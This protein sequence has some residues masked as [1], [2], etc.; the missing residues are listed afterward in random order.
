MQPNVQKHDEIAEWIRF[1]SRF[2]QLANEEQHLVQQ[3]IEARGKI[4]DLY[5][6]A[7]RASESSRWRFGGGATEDFRERV[8]TLAVEASIAIGSPKGADREDFWLHRLYLHL[9]ETKS[10]YLFEQNILQSSEENFPKYGGGIRHVC[11]ASVSFCSQLER[12]ARETSASG[13]VVAPGA[14]DRTAGKQE[15]P[16]TD[17]EQK[18]WS[19]I[20]R[21]LKGPT[22]CRE[23]H[24]AGAR[25]RK[26]W[27][28]DGC[29]GTYPGA[30]LQGQP[31]TK[32]IQDEKSKVRHKAELAGLANHSLASK[33]WA[34]I[35]PA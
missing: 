21:G 1:H 13:P 34:S 4:S 10:T 19:V 26:E 3:I 29:P 23:V 33:S 11:K 20:Q 22:Y 8:C 14:A 35:K 27:I 2:T 7:Y 18:L 24:N 28:S 15:E 17:H 6:Y 30:Y 32:R 25:P 16:L 5:L 31:W 9:R 12:K